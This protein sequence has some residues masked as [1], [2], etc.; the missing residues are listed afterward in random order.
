MFSSKDDKNKEG[1][2]KDKEPPKG[3]TNLFQKKG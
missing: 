3:F 1:D 2:F